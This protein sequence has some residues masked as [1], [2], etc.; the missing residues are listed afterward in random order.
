[1]AWY[2]HMPLHAPHAVHFA[3]STT[4]MGIPTGSHALISGLRKMWQLGAST[5]QSSRRTG[6][7][8][9]SA[10]LTAI[11]VFPVPP[12]PDAMAM[13]MQFSSW[14]LRS[15][16]CLWNF[17]DPGGGV[18][19]KIQRITGIVLEDKTRIGI[20]QRANSIGTLHVR[21]EDHY[22]RSLSSHFF[23]TQITY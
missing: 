22:I 11:V 13:V 10:R 18:S 15:C 20:A 4:G 19:G 7:G 3:L 2:W 21:K 17:A 9:A 16:P 6:L 12:L 14:R 1:M 23:L 8:A 5:S